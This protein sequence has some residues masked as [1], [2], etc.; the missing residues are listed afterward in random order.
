MTA[1]AEHVEDYLRLRRS[2]AYKLEDAG[3]LLARFSAVLDAAG[4]ECVT[5][6]AA[7]AWALEPEVAAGSIVRAA[8]L[9]AARG[10]RA[11]W[12]TSIRGPRS[13]QWG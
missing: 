10:S 13:R 7:L 6:E 11:T 1:F 4:A 2:L 3:R 5:I 8:R 9:M 12:R